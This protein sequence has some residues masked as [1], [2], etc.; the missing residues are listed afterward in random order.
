MLVEILRIFN[1]RCGA[2]QHEHSWVWMR[3]GAACGQGLRMQRS[4]R[5]HFLLSSYSIFG[6]GTKTVFPQIRE[7]RPWKRSSSQNMRKISRILGWRL[8]K[9]RSLSRNVRILRW[10]PRSGVLEDV[11]GLEDVLEDTFSSPWP[12]PRSL[13][14]SKIA[15]SSARGQQYFLNG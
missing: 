15:L 14:S 2:V 3:C 5:M 10:R 4:M 9:K 1:L 11:L 12:W 6:G 8:K 13:R 7:W